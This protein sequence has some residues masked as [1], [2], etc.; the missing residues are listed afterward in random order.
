MTRKINLN[1]RRKIKNESLCFVDSNEI[2]KSYDELNCYHIFENCGAIIGG[3]IQINHHDVENFDVPLCGKCRDWQIVLE[4]RKQ[5]RAQVENG[6]RRSRK[7]GETK[8]QYYDRIRKIKEKGG[9]SISELEDKIGDRAFIGSDD[10][11]VWH[12][13]DDCEMIKGNRA[14]PMVKRGMPFCKKCQE[15]LDEAIDRGTCNRDSNQLFRQAKS[16]PS[17]GEFYRKL[18]LAQKEEKNAYAVINAQGPLIV[19]AREILREQ[20]FHGEAHKMH[21]Q[22]PQSLRQARALSDAHARGLDDISAD[23]A[24]LAAYREK[25]NQSAEHKAYLALMKNWN[26]K[27]APVSLEP[28]QKQEKTFQNQPLGEI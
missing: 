27:K 13:F 15:K 18:A 16:K 4:E 1:W 26:P 2:F 11:S 3:A 6:A 7:F 21:V 19:K 8:S 28:D 22:T 20:G 23:S 25:K 12:A 5:L 10:Q 17:S 24:N 14:S 9:Y